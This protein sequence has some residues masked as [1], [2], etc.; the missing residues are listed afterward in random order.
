MARIEKI[1]RRPAG[2]LRPMIK[3]VSH[4]SVFVRDQDEALDFYTGK[5]GMEVREDATLEQFGGYRWL[6]VG[7]RDQPDIFIILSTPGPPAHSEETSKTILDLMAKGDAVGPGILAT[8]DC[9]ATC[10][11]L[12]A[13]GVQLAQEPEERFYGIDAAVRDPSGNLWRIVEPTE[14]DI[15]S[16]PG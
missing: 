16:L 8:D 5:L 10:E 6:T 2:S 7:P 13:K 14:Y 4:L 3:A 12:K 11:E 1:E 15:D 9:Q